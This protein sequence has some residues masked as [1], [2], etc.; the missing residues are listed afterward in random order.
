[1]FGGTF[2]KD[3]ALGPRME[4]RLLGPLEV[5]ESDRPVAL[6][7]G[8]QRALF[9]LLLIHANEVVSTDRLID[10]L[11]GDAPP[12][13]ALKSVQV[14]VSH[15]RKALGDGR[16]VTQPPG[17]VL[18]ADSS[19]VDVGCFERLVADADGM[20]P[21]IAAD[22]LRRALK[23]WHGPALADMAYEPFAQAEIA[24]LEELRAAATEKRIDADLACARHG[25]LIGELESLAAQHPY[26]ERLRA[27]L[28]L[29]LY[30]SGRQA[31]ALAA[32]RKARTE[33]S[34]GLG[35]EPSEELR[36][37]EQ[38][39]LR[40]DPSLDLPA[41]P[42]PRP[43][44]EEREEPASDESGQHAVD[45]P[46]QP[47]T[48]ARRDR[49]T[50]R[51]LL[52]AA[53]AVI[54]A[55]AAAAGVVELTDEGGSAEALAEVAPDSLAVLD[56]ETNGIVG[57]ISI[58]G[59]PSLVAADGRWV[60]VASDSAR[61]VSRIDAGRLAVRRIVPTNL[62]PTGLSAHSGTSWL[63]DQK[64]LELVKVDAAYPRVAGRLEVGSGEV[65]PSPTGV[66][67]D[68]A[69][70]AVWVADG[71]RRLLRIDPRDTTVADSLEVPE[72]LD[73]VAVGDGAIWAISAAAASVL[74]IDPASGSVRSRIRITSRPGSTRPIP[75]A[76]A[77]G[78]G[79]VWVLNGNTP[80]VSRID[81]ELGAVTHT[82][83][84]PV[85]S[86]PTAIATG[87]DA[88]WVALS[89]AGTVAR[90]E[91]D[92]GAMEQIPVGGAPTG[93]AVGVGKVWISVQP[94]FR[95]V[96][97][98]GAG[99]IRAPGSVS[100]PFCSGVEFAG[101]GAPRFLVVSDYPLQHGASPFPTLQYTDAVRFVLARRHFRA[102][103]YGVGYQSCDDSNIG[104][105]GPYAWTPATCR[106][107]ARAYADAP[108]VIGV[109]G[110][111]ESPC[112]AYQIPIHNRASNGPLAQISG[113]ATAVG[114]THVAP[115]SGEHEPDV[116]YPRGVRN[117]A[118]VVAADDF[119]GAAVAL[120][121]KKLG[122]R[123]LFVLE[124][125]TTYG[126][127][128][129]EMVRT[130]ATDLGVTVAGTGRWRYRQRDFS[131]LANAIE[132]SGADGVFL[133]GVQP[134]ENQNTPISDLHR[135]LGRR[136]QL[137]APDGFSDF[138]TL[139]REYGSA[140]EGMV[141]SFP[142][143][144]PTRFP[145]SGREFAKEFEEAVGGPADPY[146]MAVAQATEVLLDAIA[147]SDGTRASVSRNLFRTRVEDGILGDFE[148]DQNGDTT[149]GGV[150]MYRIENGRPRV[151]DVVT[152]PRSLVR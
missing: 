3:S 96:L 62:V 68:A 117:F 111:F 80:S 87:A 123:R 82:I 57:Q 112:V 43:S 76:V 152:P 122:I 102:G 98:S 42:V 103:A 35:L 92:S 31:D 124:D 151:V 79:A 5:L 90:I 27:Q 49:V 46:E 115:G 75:I 91:P 21:Q 89:G 148:I 39:I 34:E 119:Q 37:L 132:R 107:N 41:D 20:D 85:G 51:R 136:V 40:H 95:S 1:M 109:I 144:P 53:G 101:E 18:R 59:Q 118:R 4:F 13:T 114:L 83:S 137:I 105:G 56:P 14:Y 64:S 145:P 47:A 142:V 12:R 147:A 66:G 44:R 7:R 24:R 63:L 106:R 126:I 8:R 135:V 32:Y 28:M 55:A 100:E 146:S 22:G 70:S 81:P 65:P 74:E 130:A 108:R 36:E 93:V 113:S 6:G 116:Y 104:R 84:L 33:L 25:E 134:L 78:E 50:P 60:W 99:T 150:T 17:Y 29:A 52:L 61:T 54:L 88:V 73:G 11:W 94:A 19:E 69:R 16:L 38:A 128:I 77:A 23:L 120:M 127:A 71:S 30:R 110:P 140:A 15:L 125:T 2:A 129:A 97:A 121:A 143:V 131:R 133:G 138:P 72:R 149:A 86:N 58:P 45:T 9:A 67:V 48:P 141:I 139:V 10:E 26:W